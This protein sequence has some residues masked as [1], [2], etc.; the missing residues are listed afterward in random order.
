MTRLRVFA[1]AI[2]VLALQTTGSAAQLTKQ[3]DVA[4]LAYTLL[5]DTSFLHRM[6]ATERLVVAPSAQRRAAAKL[7][8]NALRSGDSTQQRNAVQGLALLGDQA[9]EAQPLLM[10][11]LPSSKSPL[12]YDIVYALGEIGSGSP[13]LITLLR[14]SEGPA[15]LSVA[16]ALTRLGDTVGAVQLFTKALRDPEQRA[17]AL[18]KL[19]ELKRAGAL[20]EARAA[21]R[22]T[23]WEVRVAAARAIGRIGPAAHEAWSDLLPLLDDTVIH[24]SPRSYVLST[25]AAS[26]A[27]WALSQTRP[28]ESSAR[29]FPMLVWVEDDTTNTVRSDG[30]GAYAWGVDSV[31]VVGGPGFFLRL[32]S[33]DSF[34]GPFGMR[35]RALR[36][37]L[38]IDL[39]RPIVASGAKKLGLLRDNEAVVNVDAEV[40]RDSSGYISGIANNDLAVSATRVTVHRFELH[41]R[42]G[43]RLHLLQIGDEWEGTA[44]GVEWATN[45]SLGRGTS[46]TLIVRA[47]TDKWVSYAPAGSVARLWDISDRAHPVDR[48]LYGFSY[49]MR[50]YSFPI[51]E[52]NEC[53]SILGPVSR[54]Q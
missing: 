2:S 21:L 8:L 35:Q 54:C 37:S 44:S 10:Q 28:V 13:D 36:R 41:F 46:N 3:D 26:V 51:D 14:K 6:A 48:G 43:G 16:F 38:L 49:Q 47:R 24:N 32:A 15:P 4:Q 29:W 50:W 18:T 22:D 9:R 5:S 17:F 39:S 20:T 7:F 19:A 42:I 53:L 27:A 40:H 1:T 45:T 25:S 34:R 23:A 12:F 30:L 52:T 31:S 33:D 11:M